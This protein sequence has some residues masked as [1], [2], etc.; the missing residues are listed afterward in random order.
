M[1][2][3]VSFATCIPVGFA[4]KDASS[5][6]VLA[7]EECLPE[8]LHMWLPKRKRKKRGRLGGCS[9]GSQGGGNKVYRLLADGQ[10]PICLSQ[11]GLRG[12]GSVRKFAFIK[13]EKYRLWYLATSQNLKI[14]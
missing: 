2:R 11:A 14:V 5:L 9:E 13:T 10:K 12:I 4:V 8:T 3:E 1:L 7:P 6:E